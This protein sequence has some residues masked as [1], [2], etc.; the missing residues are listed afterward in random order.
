MQQ[1]RKQTKTQKGQRHRPGT[2]AYATG[3]ATAASI[4]GAAHQIVI[5]EGMRAVT[6]RRIARD[7]GIS[8]GNLSYY[9]ATKTDLLE[10]LCKYVLD[11]FMAEFE[12]LRQLQAGSPEAQLR[13]VLEFVYDD[14]GNRETTNFFPE[15]WVLALRDQ[16]AAEQMERIYGLYRSVLIDIITAL[17]PELNKQTIEDIALTLSATIEGHT[18]FIGHGRQHQ[19]RAPYVKSLIIEQLIRLA[20]GAHDQDRAPRQDDQNNG[21]SYA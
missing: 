20:L 18:V 8:P 10:D 12:R 15:L 2:A 6:M 17:R 9:Y 3:Q 7:L 5:N 1:P 21:G 14:L 11:G 4:L 19:P 16:W 13:A